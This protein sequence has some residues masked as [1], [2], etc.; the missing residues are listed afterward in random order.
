MK[1]DIKQTKE[2]TVKIINTKG[3]HI[4]VKGRL[5]GKVAY[6][7]IDTGAQSSILDT[8]QDSLY[9]FR[10]FDVFGDSVGGVGGNVLKKITIANLI[11]VGGVNIV[12]KEDIQI[13]TDLMD[14][15]IGLH[16]STGYI[17]EGLI[18]GD[19]LNKFKVH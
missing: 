3:S 2:H 15:N 17:I 11:D 8:N 6:F 14:M 4:I 16:Y 12:D 10:A 19:I 1:S 9:G 18:G 7:L 13:C 5:N